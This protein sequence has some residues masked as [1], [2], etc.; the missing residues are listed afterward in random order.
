MTTTISQTTAFRLSFG[1][2]LLFF[3]VIAQLLTFSTSAQNSLF[4]YFY[5]S[6][7][8]TFPA[9]S[10]VLQQP[11]ISAEYDDY[12]C[13]KELMSKKLSYAFVKNQNGGLITLSH[14]GYSKY[15]ILTLSAGYARYFGHRLSVSMSGDYILQHAEYYHVVQSFTIDISSILIMTSKTGLLIHLYNPIR[16]R[17]GFKGHDF[18]PIQFHSEYYYQIDSK[19]ISYISCSK[20]FPGNLEMGIG[21]N[22]QPAR[23]LYFNIFC[24]QIKICAGATI[25]WNHFFFESS[26]NWNYKLG[27]STQIHL[28][29]LL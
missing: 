9:A 4:Q 8:T 28:H 23:K 11:Q 21:L 3:I 14:L 26:A 16:M 6:H 25:Q 27:I 20:T 24:S 13:T 5:V 12:F 2:I 18:I 10:A 22:C 7:A 1:N 17:Y 29:Y 19:L 15:G